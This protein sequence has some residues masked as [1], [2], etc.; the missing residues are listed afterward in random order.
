M[1]D[2]VFYM[3]MGSFDEI[4]VKCFDKGEVGTGERDGKESQKGMRG[5]FRGGGVN[6]E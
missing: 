1:G 5:Y 6:G 4:K 3:L 2:L